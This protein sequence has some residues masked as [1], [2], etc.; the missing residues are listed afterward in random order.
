MSLVER[1]AGARRRWEASEGQGVRRAVRAGRTAVRQLARGEWWGEEV[2]RVVRECAGLL[3]ARFLEGI[4]VW[5]AVF[6]L[7]LI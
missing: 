2:G 7:D 3:V 6:F 4:R 1:R 5:L